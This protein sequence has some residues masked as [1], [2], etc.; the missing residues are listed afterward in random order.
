ME[1]FDYSNRRGALVPVLPKVHA[2]LADI[3]V[4][5][6]MAALPMPEHIVTWQ[7]QMRKT[8]LQINHRFLCAIDASIL[9]GIFFYHYQGTDI[10]IDECQIA[11]TYRNNPR[12]L[13][14]LLKKLEFDTGTRNATFYASDRIKKESDKEILASVGFKEEIEGDYENLGN[15]ATMA[16]TLKLRYGMSKK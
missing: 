9:A 11:W 5:D 7:Q 3:S 10:Y 1:F 4:K 12:V 8:V 16:N 6:K 2:L 15:F 14:G 13:D